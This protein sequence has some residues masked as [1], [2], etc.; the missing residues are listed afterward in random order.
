MDRASGELRGKSIVITGASSGFGRGAAL[1]FAEAGASVA[2]AARREHLLEEVAK[3]CRARGPKAVALQADVSNP[4]DVAVLAERAVSELGAID[5]W[6]NNA[7]VGA[8]G[9]FE[10]VPLE[11]HEQVLATNLLGTLYG[12]HFAY[13]HFLERGSGILINV[14]SELGRYGAPYYASYVAATHGVV[15]LGEA[16]R[17]ELEQNGIENVHVCTVLP[18]AH[19]TPFFDHV[20]NYSGHEVQVPDRL[21]DPQNVVDALL[22]LAVDPKD[23]EIVGADGVAK[24]LLQR[25]APGVAE[26]IGGRRMHET[27]MEKAPPAPDSPGAV[28]APSEVGTEV[29][30]GRSRRKTPR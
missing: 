1:A 27:Q 21:H 5:V 30:A 22:R 16:L 14:S 15:G 4:E 11:D 17:Q 26:K 7:G 18:A 28:R 23:Q 13:R 12:S 2:L 29:S 20:A 8:I 3:E 9:R 24:I 6:I 25:L 10:R 19:D